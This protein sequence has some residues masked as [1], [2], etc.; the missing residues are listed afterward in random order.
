M[1]ERTSG[2]RTNKN[3]ALIKINNH[4]PKLIME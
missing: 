4:N 1:N 3:E 2:Y